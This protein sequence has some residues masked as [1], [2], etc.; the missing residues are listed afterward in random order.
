VEGEAE[1]GAGGGD[2]EV[3]GEDHRDPHADRG[4]VDGGDDGLGVLEQLEGKLREEVLLAEAGPR[5]STL[6]GLVGS[7]VL[8][9]D[10]R[11]EAASRAGE[12]HGT[13]GRVV[14][15]LAEGRH[16]GVAHLRR[17][18]VEL[19]GTVERDGGHAVFRVDENRVDHHEPV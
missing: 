18:G 13:D 8:E 4:A 12:D 2:A 16:H 19:V 5:R 7:Q 6:A 15:H 14:A 10:T 17:V 3:A 1:L 9:V 11:A